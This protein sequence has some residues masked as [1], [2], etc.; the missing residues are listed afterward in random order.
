MGLEVLQL[1]READRILVRVNEPLDPGVEAPELLDDPCPHGAQRRRVEDDLPR[2]HDW[3]E[4]VLAG[5]PRRDVLII[6]RE[7][8]ILTGEETPS[9]FGI[10]PVSVI[11][12]IILTGVAFAWMRWSQLGRSQYAIGGNKGTIYIRAEYPL[13]IERLKIAIKQAREYGLLGKDI[14]GSGF[15]F[16]I[17]LKYGAG[18]FVCG[19]ETALIHSIEGKRGMPRPRPPFPAVSGLF[20]KPT[21]I[22]NVETFSA[23]SERKPRMPM[24][25]SLWTRLSVLDGTGGQTASALL[26]T[27]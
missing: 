7:A 20:G 11:I 16:D 14:L 1:L 10:L 26:V 19:E 9:P 15:N 23:R 21:I 27:S 6:P 2:A 25:S 12:M 4:E 22:N 3:H 13:A 18:A 17:D 8:L 5:G 24:S